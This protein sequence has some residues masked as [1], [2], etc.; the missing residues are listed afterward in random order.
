MNRFAVAHC[1]LLTL[2]GS[3]TSAVAGWPFFAEDG[4]RRGSPEYYQA[5]ANDP[6]GARQKCHHGKLWP[7]FPRP[8]GP[9][10]TFVHKYHSSHYWPHPYVCEDRA[11]VRSLMQTQTFNGWQTATT[12]YGYHFDPATHTLNAAGRTQLHWILT[13]APAEY[14]QAN[15]AIADDPQFNDVRVLSVEREIA[16]VVGN[17]QSVP[18]LLRA[19]EPT[20]RPA[21]EVQSIFQGTRDNM[22][23]PIIPYTSASAGGS[24]G[25]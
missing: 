2:V 21:E 3:T 22:L 14:R 24:E 15:I 7:P 9:K 6:V 17:H 5:H 20:G 1:L 11:Y 25:G 19:A 18:V 10:Q 8:V 4:I 12:L 23:P 16:R 13:H